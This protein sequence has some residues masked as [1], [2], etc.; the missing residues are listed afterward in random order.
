[1]MNVRTM[2]R[3]VDAMEETSGAIPDVVK[4]AVSRW[5]GDVDTTK[6]IRSS[7]NH[8]FRFEQNGAGCF[9]R[10][11]PSSERDRGAVEGE[12]EFVLH[13]A[14][15]D[16]P[17]ARPLKSTSASFIEEIPMDHEPLYAVVFKQL[18]GETIKF[19]TQQAPMFRAWGRALGELHNAS[20]SL[21]D[22]S[23]G[24]LRAWT[25]DIRN[26]RIRGQ[27]PNFAILNLPVQMAHHRFPF[28][29]SEASYGLLGTAPQF[30]NF[31]SPWPS[32]SPQVPFRV[33]RSLLRF[34]GGSP[35]IPV[36]E[37]FSYFAPCTSCLSKE[38]A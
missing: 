28:V 4:L 17:V 15:R 23:A 32:R 37:G 1:M 24:K 19:E 9:L 29:S 2:G 21:A 30:Y 8:I 34:L 6:Y 11:T 13:V 35:P 12:V 25:D 10:L 27:P 36:G 26:A 16:V 38:I 7:N 5:N 33:L 31:E 18:T 3:I 20:Q 14:A 22:Q